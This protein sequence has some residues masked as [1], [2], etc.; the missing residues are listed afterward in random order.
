MTRASSRP[1]SP[2]PRWMIALLLA[3]SALRL[4][5]FV[6][7]AGSD[8]SLYLYIGQRLL[9]GD[10]PY[11]DA[12]D[13]KPPL[14][15]AIYATLWSIWPHAS[16]V[17]LA[18]L[19][20]AAGTAWLL[21]AIGRRTF[22]A[23]TGAWAAALF[24]I[25]SHPGLSRLGGVYVR[26]QC[27]VFISF[28]VAAALL[29]L[30]H[31]R[32]TVLRAL[33][34]GLW[35][36][37]AIWLKFNAAA[38]VLPVAAAA[39]GWGG[40]RQDLRG[41]TRDLIAAATG[42]VFV[43]AIALT[44]FAAHD[45]LDPLKLATIDY[46]IAYS[47]AAYAGTRGPL[48]YLAKLPIERGGV[49]LLWFLGGAGALALVVAGRRAPRGSAIVVLAWIAA[50][51]IAIAINARNLPQYFVQAAPA[52]ACAA[53]IG[54]A[55]FSGHAVGRWLVLATMAA[56]LW[57]VGVSDRQI[58]F[59][60]LP[61]LFVNL[62]FDLDYARGNI[63]RQN[64]LS[65]FRGAQK[66]DAPEIDALTTL[67][68][69]TTAESDRILVFGFSPGVYAFSHRQSASR[70]FW[71]YPVVLEFAADHAGYGSA[72]LLHELQ[73]HPPALIALQK[74]D[75]GPADPNSYDFFLAN[76]GLRLWLQSSYTRESDSP[77][78]SV[79]RRKP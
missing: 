57:R 41:W 52:L 31:E 18:D 67:V 46:N 77:M 64:Y 40:G 51:M 56:G 55:L 11:V 7:P 53:A 15:Y 8:Q 10:V 74:Q 26:G 49:D 50:A 48:V 73:Q 36:G 35:L 60:D 44:W 24:L 63:S 37:A 66:Y 59:G 14:V 65:R 58:R 30:A 19:L 68:R 43:S 70:F 2:I 5:A 42:V 3:L 34:A 72:G 29:P 13:Q 23:R 39:W 28:A 4:P 1:A 71:S 17:A 45:A 32:R 21:V 16:V 38:Y 9:A 79:W 6:E 25:G 12:W 61:E 54:G 69:T 76:T 20:A 33:L 75:Y 27:E 78:F 47:S 22:G 62:R